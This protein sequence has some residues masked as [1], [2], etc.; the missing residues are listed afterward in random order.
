M[1]RITI[2]GTTTWGITLGVVLAHKGLDVRLWARTA[3][4]A[5]KLKDKGPDPHLLPGITLP[6]Q[7]SVT[8]S[9]SEALA[10]VNAIILAV[11]S[12]SMRQNI[13]SVK[14][15]LNKSTLVISAAKGIEIGS[16]KRMSEVIA[17]EINPR[18]R[19]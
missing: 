7:L 1:P 11:P 13:V 17:E 15:Y 8:S 16:N 2:I 19:L 18:L 9:L 3:K 12:Q 5:D 4:E 14:Y 6:P 10:Y